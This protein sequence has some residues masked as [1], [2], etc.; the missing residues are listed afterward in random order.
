MTTKLE[1]YTG[2]WRRSEIIRTTHNGNILM[3]D[4]GH[5]PTEIRLTLEAI[6]HKYPD[7]K[8]LV[9]FQPHQHSR[10]RELLGEFIT[11]FK[12]V[13]DL[14]IPNIY[15]SRDSDEDVAF[16]TTERFIDTIRSNVPAV[17][18][19]GGLHGT[20]ELIKKYDTEN[21]NSSVMVLL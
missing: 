1:S 13:D 10:T 3:S 4:Y 17:Q 11:A 16:M 7:K 6:A 15:F 2:C 8:L 12:E 18:N 9:A 20:A 21:P 19:G 5:H 14:I